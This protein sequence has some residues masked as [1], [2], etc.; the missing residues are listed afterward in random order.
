M[1]YFLLIT[2]L[3]L[4]AFAI[5]SKARHPSAIIIAVLIAVIYA[6]RDI[7]VGNDTFSY[8]DYHYN[9]HRPSIINYHKHYEPIYHLLYKSFSNFR[10]VQ[11]TIFFLN[12]YFLLN[13]CKTAKTYLSMIIFLTFLGYLNILTDQTRQIFAL[14][15]LGYF[16]SINSRT[17]NIKKTGT[18]LIHYSNLLLIGFEFLFRKIIRRISVYIHLT[19]L[20]VSVLLGLRNFWYDFTFNILSTLAPET[21]Y[22]NQKFYTIYTDGGNGLIFFRFIFGILFL[23]IFSNNNHKNW[24]NLMTLGLVLQI[25]SNGFMPIERIGNGFFFLSILLLFQENFSYQFRNFKHNIIYLLAFVYFIALNVFDL[26][27][28]GSVPWIF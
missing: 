26:E 19:I 13:I 18:I 28:H 4:H 12:F 22:L 24:Y 11:F 15:V 27:K 21:S 10:I 25:S 7:S 8:W 20:L 6:L 9:L 3:S 1:I 14:T 2:I 16:Y 5:D 23:I 17:K